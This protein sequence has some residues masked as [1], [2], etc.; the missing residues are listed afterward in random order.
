MSVEVS[1]V[2]VTYNSREDIGAC[3]ASIR[4]HTGA[5]PGRVLRRGAR[6]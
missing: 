5:R 2:I 4:E 1:V 3:L 6:R